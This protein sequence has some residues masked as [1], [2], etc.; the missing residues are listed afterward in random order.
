MQRIKAAIQ[1]ELLMFE[2]GPRSQIREAALIVTQE[3]WS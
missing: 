2:S 3:K 1:T